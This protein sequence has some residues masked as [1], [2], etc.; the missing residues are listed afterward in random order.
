M[1]CGRDFDNMDAGYESD[2]FTIDFVN[3][4]NAGESIS[5]VVFSIAVMQG[6]DAGA[7]TRLS[8]GPSISTTKVSQA[9]DVRGAPSGVLYRLQATIATNQRVAISLWSHFWSRSPA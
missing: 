3:D 7:A 5:S 6:T 2:V 1:Y 9:V 8:G 4:L